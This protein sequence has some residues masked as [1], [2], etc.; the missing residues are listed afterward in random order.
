MPD[1]NPG[2]PSLARAEA[3]VAVLARILHHGTVEQTNVIDDIMATVTPRDSWTWT[4]GWAWAAPE[5]RD[6]VM[7]LTVNREHDAIKA[8]YTS[9]R[10]RYRVTD[11]G[12][13]EYSL[14]TEWF[15]VTESYAKFESL[16][17]GSTYAQSWALISPSD[18]QHGITGEIVWARFPE[19]DP[20]EHTT[21]A[22]R[23]L[24]FR[25]YV[26]ALKAADVDSIINLM[27][28]G[29]QGGVRDY[30]GPES[31]AYIDGADAM[32]DYYRRMFAMF[33]VIDVVPTMHI[34]R[35]WYITCENRWQVEVLQGPDA[36]T[37]GT[38]LVAENLGLRQDGRIYARLGFG[39][40]LLR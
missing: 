39:T 7:K 11:T 21:G 22:D 12:L 14:A 8:F 16:S 29:V 38:L 23:A 5:K 2:H 36:G 27:D 17:D 32:R 26:A 30:N 33:R 4:T 28:A 1:I 19:L 6:G 35:G 37:R 13:P 40:G 31:F 24:I 3:G 9:T 20:T 15:G 25:D 18:G 10:E 34:D